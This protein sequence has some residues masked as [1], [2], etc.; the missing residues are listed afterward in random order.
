MNKPS[1]QIYYLNPQITM[2]ISEAFFK[3]LYR[4]GEWIIGGS[5]WQ[6]KQ[7]E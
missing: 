7:G 4:M 1:K 3:G 6:E 2:K 5:W